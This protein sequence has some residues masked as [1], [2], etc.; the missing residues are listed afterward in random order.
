MM[1]W[2]KQMEAEL[3]ELNA[4]HEQLKALPLARG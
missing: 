1:D 4:E 3:E 2:I